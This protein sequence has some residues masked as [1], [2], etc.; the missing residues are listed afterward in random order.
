MPY[1]IGA[2]VI[3]LCTLAGLEILGVKSREVGVVRAFVG[4]AIMIFGGFLTSIILLN[5]WP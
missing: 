4:C 5:T 3:A 2:L 1:V